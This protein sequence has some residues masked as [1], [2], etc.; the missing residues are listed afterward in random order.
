[1]VENDKYKVDTDL[2]GCGSDV[3]SVCSLPG[4]GVGSDTVEIGLR[5]LTNRILDCCLHE[6]ARRSLWKHKNNLR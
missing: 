2:E 5:W 3:F 6:P 4:W 1:M